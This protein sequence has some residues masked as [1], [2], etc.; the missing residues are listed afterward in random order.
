MLAIALFT[1]LLGLC[2]LVFGYDDLRRRRAV[3]NAVVWGFGG[4]VVIGC[5]VVVIVHIPMLD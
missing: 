1:V 4:L 2:A 3:C 5:G